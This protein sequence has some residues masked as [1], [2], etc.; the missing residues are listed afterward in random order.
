MA[1]AAL[2]FESANQ[3]APAGIRSAI[4]RA[5][6]PATGRANPKVLIMQY[7]EGGN[8]YNAFNLAFGPQ[9]IPGERDELDGHE[10]GHQLRT[11]VRPM[12]TP[13]KVGTAP[14]AAGYSNYMCSTGGSASQI[15]GGTIASPNEET[16]Q[17][18]LGVFNVS[19]QRAGCG[20]ATPPT[21]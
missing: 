12:A 7:L 9:R 13:S 11:F 2:N 4:R 5:D 17:S 1:L 19:A 8:T 15:F 20:A 3:P 18:F 16:N 6:A 21:P 14:A 10:P